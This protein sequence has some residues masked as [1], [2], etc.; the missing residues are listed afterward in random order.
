MKK[1]L[2]SRLAINLNGFSRS[3][4]EL[5]VGFLNTFLNFLW[6][7]LRNRSMGMQGI[8]YEIHTPQGHFLL[9]AEKGNLL[10]ACIVPN[11]RFCPYK[12]KCT[13]SLG[14]IHGHVNQLRL[15]PLEFENAKMCFLG[16]TEKS[17]FFAGPM[18]DQHTF[19]FRLAMTGWLGRGRTPQEWI[20]NRKESCCVVKPFYSFA[21]FWNKDADVGQIM[22]LNVSFKLG[23]VICP[24]PLT[25]IPRPSDVPPPQTCQRPQIC[26]PQWHATPHTAARAAP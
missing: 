8:T 25:D 2:P 26:H 18:Q 20:L 12:L 21:A 16:R 13:L 11:A 3:T 19:P 15:W 10:V 22:S 14:P 9:G 24:P 7:R 4:W 6:T 23:S 1:E 17:L 5:F